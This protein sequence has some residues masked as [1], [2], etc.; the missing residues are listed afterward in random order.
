[1]IVFSLNSGLLH[2]DFSQGEETGRYTTTCA[3]SGE[4]TSRMLG[5]SNKPSFAVSSRHMRWC[6]CR[7]ALMSAGHE[8]LYGIDRSR[9]YVCM[10]T[11]T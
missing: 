10:C 1:M 8:K 9:G 4:G 3:C 2:S 7:H 11:R 5:C 6:K